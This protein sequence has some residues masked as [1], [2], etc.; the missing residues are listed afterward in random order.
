MKSCNHGEIIMRT[1]RPTRQT[2]ILWVDH[3]ESRQLLSTGAMPMHIAAMVHH[4]QRM[5][6][7]HAAVVERM[8]SGRHGEANPATGA[9]P[10]TSTG[11]SVVAQ[12]SNST[13]VGTAA[14]ADSD[15]WVVGTTNLDTSSDTPLAVHF[16]GT[17]WSAVPTPTLKGRADFEGVAAAASN[18][19]W[20]V[21][22]QNISSTGMAQPLIE[23]WN[24]TS[25][26][27]V[28]SPSLKQG[29]LLNAVTAISTNNVW[30]V[31]FFDNFSSDLVEHW[32][33]TS[34]SI[35]SSPAFNDGGALDILYGVSAD[36]SNDIW[37]VGNS[38]GGLILHFDGTNWSRT[39]LPSPRYGFMALYADAALSPSDV[40]AMGARKDRSKNHAVTER[41]D[42]T[43]WSAVSNPSTGGNLAGAAAISASDIWAVGT[44]GIENWNGTSWSFVKFPSG[45]SG[46]LKGVAAL[47]DGTVVTVSSGGSIVEN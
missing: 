17:S 7:H 46:A 9:A 35:V 27:V 33:G 13:F 41:W 19:V 12:F 11:F 42:G 14:I 3:L 8:H 43:S 4:H 31:G 1:R 2:T 26:S 47:S 16:D 21:G 44:T 34:W 30:A 22:A 40:W 5:A 6:V 36:A 15:I 37:A 29:G 32:D 38:N 45:V 28:S 23:H 25:W 20:A 24:G 10:A 18:D 39:V